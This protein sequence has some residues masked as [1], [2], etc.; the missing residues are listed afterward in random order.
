MAAAGFFQNHE[1]T[2]L[3]DA[4]TCFYCD[5]TVTQWIGRPDPAT[6]HA[7]EQPACT[8]I[9]GKLMNTQEDREAT[10]D[11]WP[12]E[13]RG[14]FM[15]VAA[16]GFY[17]SNRINHAVTCYSCNLTLRPDQLL[18]DPLQA[19]ATHLGG[20]KC[21]VIKGASRIKVEHDTMRPTWEA[22]SPSRQLMDDFKPELPPSP[23]STSSSPEH[24]CGKCGKEFAS[25][26][27]VFGHL[28]RVHKINQCRQCRVMCRSTD[29]LSEHLVTA[30]GTP[31]IT[32][33]V[34]SDG[35]VTKASGKN[36]KRFRHATR[37]MR[38]QAKRR[39]EVR[40]DDVVIKKEP[41]FDEAFGLAMMSG[42]IDSVEP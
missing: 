6:V 16:A 2:H 37:S 30:H 11:N 5:L 32:K 18:S 38:V 17:Q 13:G 34:H 26:T 25:K 23:P 29:A 12:F 42:A 3:A 22:A 31:R 40:T 15:M 33:I 1:Y 41:D 21:A 9:F 28:K 19:H 20:R 14:S 8:W 39:V 4:A 24:T 27:K 35:R 36:R 7:T 10:F